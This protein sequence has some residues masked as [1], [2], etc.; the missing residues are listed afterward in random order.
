[1]ICW[2]ICIPFEIGE[3]KGPGYTKDNAICELHEEEKFKARVDWLPSFA[4][5][6][7]DRQWNDRLA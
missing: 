5:V 7:S 3:A 6:L 4:N 2:R 1:M